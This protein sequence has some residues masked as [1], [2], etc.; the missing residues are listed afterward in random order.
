MA[1]GNKHLNIENLFSFNNEF[2]KKKKI[3]FFLNM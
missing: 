3:N 1:E 2:L